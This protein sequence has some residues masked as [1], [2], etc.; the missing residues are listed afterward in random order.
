MK[1]KIVVLGGSFNPPTRAHQ[2]FLLGA[3]NAIGADRGIY[4]PSPYAYVKKKMNKTP[5]PSEVIDE[6]L[7]MK[8]LLAMAS[9]DPRL[10]ADDFEYHQTGKT[11]TY[12]TLKHI[13]EN[14]PDAEIYLLAGADKLREMP[15]WGCIDDLLS[16][17]HILVTNRDGI[18]AR[19]EI[20]SNPKLRANQDHFHIV[21][22]PDDLSGI[23]ASAVRE[24]IR[25]KDET[26]L[27][28]LLH[29]DV[30]AMVSTGKIY[31]ID[32]FRD[33]Y[34]FLSNFAD[35]PM[36]YDG[37]PYRN[38]EA[39]FQAQK[40]LT[41]EEKKAF[42]E[43]SAGTAKK[44]GKTVS[45]RPDWESVKTDLMES[46]VR[47]KF[48]QN[49]RHAKALSDTAPLDLK[50]GNHWH[51]TFWGIDSQTGKGENHLGKILMKIRDGLIHP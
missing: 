34:L 21:T 10:G 3:L 43:M 41:E 42:S 4:T 47:E 15:R 23:S 45:L 17:F 14:N 46:V 9:E 35:A 13:R 24:A 27:C 20:L 2:S 30:H 37:I 11:Y 51:D 40:C 1:Q 31:T 48:L 19:A 16:E 33:E 12:D 44:Y 50:E 25:K 26:K 5:Y 36:V 7:R 8:M 39:A 28:E 29:P 49:P 18:D 6:K 22:L 38:A 32:R